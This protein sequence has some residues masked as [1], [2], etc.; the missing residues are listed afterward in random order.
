MELV[1]LAGFEPATHAAGRNVF[2]TRHGGKAEYSRIS[3]VCSTM[4]SYR[5]NLR[6][7]EASKIA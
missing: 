2:L 6:E 5:P 3:A 7:L 1:G 4:L